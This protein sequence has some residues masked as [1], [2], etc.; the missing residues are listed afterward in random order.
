MSVFQKL[1][2]TYYDVIS[3]NDPLKLKQKL[4]NII[5]KTEH[6]KNKLRMEKM[7]NYMNLKTNLHNLTHIQLKKIKTI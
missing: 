7:K 5:I 2:S 4:L 1:P 3:T 6:N